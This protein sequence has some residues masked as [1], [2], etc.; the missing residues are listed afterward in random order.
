MFDLEPLHPCS[1]VDVK[2]IRNKSFKE[3]NISF[4]PRDSIALWIVLNKF[5]TDKTS[6]QHLEP[7]TFFSQFG[8]VKNHQITLAQVKKYK[9]SVNTM[10]IYRLS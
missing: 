4:T 5:I 3:L 6:I 8:D 1:A 10:K 2:T 9:R 7:V